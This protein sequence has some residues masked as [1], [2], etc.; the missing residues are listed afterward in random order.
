VIDTITTPFY[1]A[2]NS[3]DYLLKLITQLHSYVYK[4]AKSGT[5]VIVS[6]LALHRYKCS[7][8]SDDGEPD[9]NSL[10]AT[11]TDLSVESLQL[12]DEQ[13]YDTNDLEQALGSFFGE[14]FTY[15]FLLS[16]TR[17][18]KLKSLYFTINKPQIPPVETPRMLTLAERYDNCTDF[19][20][21]HLFITDQGYHEES[22]IAKKR[23]IFDGWNMLQSY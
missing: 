8:S 17:C 16:P 5:T 19:D 11:S 14:M 10:N 21:I 13:D 18:P 9:N 3:N 22:T 6:N 2:S 15:R 1:Q 12:S 23:D 4:L 7:E 20:P